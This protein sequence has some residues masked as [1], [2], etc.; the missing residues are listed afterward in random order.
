MC[1]SPA[2]PSGALEPLHY[3]EE[4]LLNVRR[5][6]I[7]EDASSLSIGDLAERTGVPVGTLRTWESRYGLPVPRRVAGGHRRYDMAA[8]ELVQ[9][10]ARQ[11]ASGLSMPLAVERAKELLGQPES[12]VFA[13]VRRRHPELRTQSLPKPAVLALSRAIEDECC[14]QAERPLLLASFQLERYYRA[15]EHRWTELSRTAQG[16]VVFA[17]F[18]RL[19]AEHQRPLEVPVPFDAPLNREWVL[20]CDAPDF[21]GCVVGW[22]RPEVADLPDGARRFETFWSVDARVVRHA[23]RICAQLGR[24]YGAETP[25][26][27]QLDETPP[28]AS[29]ATRRASGVLDRMLGYLSA[30]LV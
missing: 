29:E 6:T 12:S 22:E 8:V 18:P 28:E 26:W 21:P 20:V 15:S 13:G 19:R 2:R 11:R 10:A 14:A 16:T 4:Y 9:E 23:A 25:V 1:V 24:L 17:D 7:A 3:D 27:P 5:Q 30:E